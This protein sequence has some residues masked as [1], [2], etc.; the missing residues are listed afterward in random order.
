MRDLMEVLKEALEEEKKSRQRY[1]QYAAAASSLEARIV[2]EN[3][4]REEELHEKRLDEM[5]QTL[6]LAREERKKV[7]AAGITPQRF[8]EYIKTLRETGFMAHVTENRLV[9]TQEGINEY[10]RENFKD[11]ERLEQAEVILRPDRIDFELKVKLLRDQPSAPVSTSVRLKDFYFGIYQKSFEFELLEPRDVIT[12]SL[13][14]RLLV[15]I[16]AYMIQ[17]IMN[18]KIEVSKVLEDP[19]FLDVISTRVR[20]DLNRSPYFKSIFGSRIK[21]LRVFD[22]LRIDQIEVQTGQI[23]VHPHLS[24]VMI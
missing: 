22:F 17:N 2:F 18:S 1:Q 5:L 4:A 8:Q 19:D 20:C 6:K 3:L 21:G 9:L 7:E 15:G 14:G 10:I 23:V 24:M 11:I 12:N 13:V 16:L